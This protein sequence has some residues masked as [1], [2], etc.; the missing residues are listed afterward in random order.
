VIGELKAILCDM[1]GVLVDSEALHWETVHDVLHE[2]GA[3]REGERLPEQIGWGDHE[4]WA[5]QRAR[6]ALSQSAEELTSLRAQH[7]ERRLEATPPPCVPGSLE[8]LQALKRAHPTLRL[9]VVSAS[10]LRQ[11]EQSLSAYEGLFELMVS[12]VDHCEHNKPSPEP[13]LTAMAR[14]GLSPAECGVIEDSPTGLRAALSSEA[15]VWCLG[16]AEGTEMFEGRL[17]GRL[18]HITELS[19]APRPQ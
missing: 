17:T 10:P 15:H 2:L 1:D 9:A 14:L 7:A 13:Y 6:Y 5:V 16:E 4:L 12:G 8:G 11:M 18:K 3:L 19:R